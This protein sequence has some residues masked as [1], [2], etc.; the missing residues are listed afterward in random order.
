VMEEDEKSGDFLF[1]SIL[2]EVR[3]VSSFSEE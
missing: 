3:G 1:F 2:E